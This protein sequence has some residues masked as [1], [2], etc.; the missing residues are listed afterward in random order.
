MGRSVAD[1]HASSP[2]ELRERIDAARRGM[3]FL[4]WRDADGRQLVLALAPDRHRV[5]LG[6]SS[7]AD[8]SLDGDPRVSRL[9]A[10]LED[11]GG[12]WVLVD[13]GLSRHGSK[14]NGEPVAG[15][16]RLEHGDVITLGESAVAFL[17]PTREPETATSTGTGA[18]IPT[19]SEADR[20]ALD[21]LCAP[22]WGDPYAPPAS[23]REIADAL[24]LSEA[25]VKARLGSLFVRFGVADLPQNQKRG[26]LAAAAVR[27]GLVRPL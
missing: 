12:A 18:A 19:L 6:R 14:V 25:R 10:V 1:L 23:N 20:R 2:A 5:T 17:A 13:D 7:H 16:R 27:A 3:P 8:V 21:A 22:L 24:C 11:V 9:H 26:A 15:R 4:A